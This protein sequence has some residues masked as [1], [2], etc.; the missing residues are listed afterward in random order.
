M[1]LDGT[2]EGANRLK[3]FGIAATARHIKLKYIKIKFFVKAMGLYTHCNV[4]DTV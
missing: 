3:Y 2:F 4:S 1:T